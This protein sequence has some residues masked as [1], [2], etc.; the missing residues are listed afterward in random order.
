MSTILLRPKEG[1]TATV[2]PKLAAIAPNQPG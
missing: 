1:L 2:A